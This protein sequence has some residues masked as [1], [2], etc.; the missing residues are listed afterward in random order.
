V[1]NLPP[2]SLTLVATLAKNSG[3]I[4]RL[5]VDAGGKFATNVVDNGGAL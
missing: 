1:A 3:E 5:V 4:C 2:E